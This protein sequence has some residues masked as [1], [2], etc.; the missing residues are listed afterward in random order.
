M[1]LNKEVRILLRKQSR[2]GKGSRR[3]YSRI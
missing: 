3:V 1:V 2:T